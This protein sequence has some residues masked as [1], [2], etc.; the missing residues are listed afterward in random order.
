M[1]DESEDS[2]GLIHP[3]SLIRQPEISNCS[4]AY[5]NEA[6]HVSAPNGRQLAVQLTFG[7]R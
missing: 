4:I 5:P 6:R 7:V 1:R 2:C 3:S